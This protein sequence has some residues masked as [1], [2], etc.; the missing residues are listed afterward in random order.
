MV[1]HQDSVSQF[2]LQPSTVSEPNFDFPDQFNTFNHWQRPKM[3]RR[4]N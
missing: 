3:F 4:A 1:L 2:S